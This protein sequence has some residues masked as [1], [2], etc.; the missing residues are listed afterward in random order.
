M[1][2]GFFFFMVCTGALSR[3]ELL[4]AWDLITW[5]RQEVEAA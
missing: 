1:A 4:E 3:E 2:L 5:K